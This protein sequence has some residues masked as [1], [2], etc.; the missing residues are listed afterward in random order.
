[1]KSLIP[2]IAIALAACSGAERSDAPATEPKVLATANA[3]DGGPRTGT[4]E[5]SNDEGLLTTVTLNADGTANYV[6]ADGTR[7][8][9][10]HRWDEENG[11]F[12]RTRDG[13]TEEVCWSHYVDEY[14]VWRATNIADESQKMTIKRIA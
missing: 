10:K 5:I 6:D 14:N 11:D 4:F 7:W 3:L 8:S 9:A 2:L 13:E 1:M 12:C